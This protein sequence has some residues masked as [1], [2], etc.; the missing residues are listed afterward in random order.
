MR[1]AVVRRGK[2]DVRKKVARA[3]SN[4]LSQTDSESGSLLEVAP[5]A[6]AVGIAPTLAVSKTGPPLGLA[7]IWQTV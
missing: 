6:T 5:L 3:D 4:A 7:A 2:Q 1:A